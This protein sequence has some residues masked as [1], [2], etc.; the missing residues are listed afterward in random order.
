VY[1]DNIV[2]VALKSMYIVYFKIVLGNNFDITSLGELKFMLGIFVICHY[3]NQ[4]IFLSQSTYIHQVL[5]CF[6]IQDIIPFS[7]SLAIKHNLS[8]SQSPM[9]ETEKY[10]YKK[11]TSNI[12]YLSLIESFFITQTWSNI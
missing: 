2:V 5:T 4:L 6:G 9:L 11:Y 10:A 12:H 8:V 7:T 3:T 1:I